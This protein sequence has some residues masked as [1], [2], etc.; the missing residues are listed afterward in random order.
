[1]INDAMIECE[2]MALLEGNEML[3]ETAKCPKCSVTMDGVA[4]IDV[5]IIL[6][7]PFTNPATILPIHQP[8]HHSLL[9]LHANNHYSY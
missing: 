4:M 8:C 1:M 7:I 6:G 2:Y 9:H 3:T 5:S